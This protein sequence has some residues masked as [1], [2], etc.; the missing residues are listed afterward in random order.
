[1]SQEWIYTFV[2]LA[3]LVGA[4]CFV[5]GLHRMNSPATGRSGNQL[6]AAGMV[7]AVSATL[8][9]LLT[10]EGGLSGHRARDHRGRLPD[11]RRGGPVH[12]PDREDD[13]DAAAGVAVQRGRRR[14]GGPRRD[15]RL[16]PPVQRRRG[17]HDH[18][19][20][21]G[22]ADR[23]DH[24]HRL[25]DRRRQAPGPDPGQA[26]LPAR[27]AVHHRGPRGRRGARHRGA[28]RGRGRRD[29]AHQRGH[30]RRPR[31]RRP[32]RADLRDHDGAADRRRRHARRHQPP[33][34]VH[35]HG[36]G[37]GRVRAR[38][39]RADHLGRPR[40]RLGRDPDQADGRRDEPVGDE[41]HGRRVRRRG[42]RGR[43]GRGRRRDGARDRRRRRRDPARLRPARDHR[44]GLRPRGGP[45]PA[46]R[47]RA[48]RA[49]RGARRRREV[50]DPPGR[51]PD[52][53]AHERAARRGERPV[54]PA[55]GDGRHQPGV[56]P[57]GRRPRHRRQRRHQPGG[58]PARARRSRGCRSS[59]STTRSRSS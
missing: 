6:S 1:M 33:E 57:G 52:A 55:Q 46:R 27:R 19:R 37:D 51:R 35:G 31:P 36:R 25:A 11:R 32:V 48:G 58:A 40:R 47:A 12:G 13:R 42:R 26:D 4:S 5:L 53:R 21:P 39:P 15:R 24:V 7:I 49:A 18:L 22:R 10:R 34:L 14:R 28:H 8:V 56:R 44:P 43:R 23:L 2:Y 30:A 41:H 54:P 50:R 9:W 3:W 29:H 59:T 20:R 17:R 38:Q 45:G 16:H